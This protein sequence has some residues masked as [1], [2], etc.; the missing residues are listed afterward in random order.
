MKLDIVKKGFGLL[1]IF[2][3][4]SCSLDKDPISDFSEITM[5]SSDESGDRIKFENRSEMLT[6]YDAM[7]ELFRGRQEHWYLDYLLLTEARADNAYGGTTGAEVMPVEDNSLDGGNSV[8]TRD[9]NS[10]LDDIA[11]VNSIIENIDLVPDASFSDSERA[12]WKAEAKIFRAMVMLDMVRFW[13][14]IPV[15]TTEAEDITADNI[16]EVYPAYFPSQNTPEEAYQQIVEDLTTAIPDAPETG[17][18][19]TVLSKAVARALL[20]KAY[21]EKPIR[22][23][24]KVIEYCD[25]VINDNFSLVDDYSLLFRMNEAGTD[26]AARNTTESIFEVQ[27]FTG[28]GNW[29]NWMFGRNLLNWDENFSWAKWVTPSRDLIAAFE[30]EGDEI[31]FNQSVVYYEPG[32]SLYYPSDHYPFMYKMRSGN[33]SIIKLR[34]ADILL[35]KAE[36]LVAQGQL[37]EAASIVDK[38]RARVDLPGLSESVKSSAE[39]MKEAVLRERRLELAFEGNRLFDLIRNDKLQSVMNGINTRD[40]GRLSQARPFTEDSELLPIPQTVLD[41]NTNL[42]QNPGY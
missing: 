3:A 22:D 28:S 15:I 42:E 35:L 38:I 20:A 7:Y 40:N 37:G 25:D 24:G 39:Q 9:W 4:A 34:L 11:H 17:N 5:G 32:W 23:Y 26:I 6:Q 1:M 19:K 31:R 8:I 41:V 18:E 2:I 30:T 33:N 10:Y 13:G 12:Q 27:F 29:V 16:E 14:N 36:A 21:A